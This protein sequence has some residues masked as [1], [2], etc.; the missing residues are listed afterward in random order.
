[1]FNKKKY[2]SNTLGFG[3]THY[4]CGSGIK[5]TFIAKNILKTFLKKTKYLRI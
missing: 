3:K 1:M 4:K 5:S 2:I